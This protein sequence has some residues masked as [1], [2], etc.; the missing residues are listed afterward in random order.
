MKRKWIPFEGTA[1]K[2]PI[3]Q[4]PVFPIAL[5]LL[6]YD[7]GKQIGI[8]KDLTRVSSI[9]SSFQ[10]NLENTKLAKLA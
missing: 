1:H 7:T 2:R 4:F 6:A 9:R 10:S 8:S 5:K 3:G